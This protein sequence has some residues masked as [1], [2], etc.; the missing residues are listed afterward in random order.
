[1][2]RIVLAATALAVL[3]AGSTFAAAAPTAARPGCTGNPDSVSQLNFPV[4][5]EMAKALVAYP[6]KAPRGIVAFAHGYGHTMHSWKRHVARTAR[7][8]GVIAVVPNYRHQLDIPPAKGKTLPSSRGWRVAEG[9]EDIIAVTQLL[10]RRC[11]PKGLNVLYGISMGGNTSGLVLAAKPKAPDGSPLFDHWVNIEGA[12][13]VTETYLMARAIAPGN[14]YAK[15]A[16]EDIEQEMGGPIESRHAVYAERTVVNRVGD[17]GASGVKSV[18]MVH[19]VLDGLV[20][21]DHSRQLQALLVAHRIPVGMRTVVTRS[22]GS[23]PGTTADGYVPT[24]QTSPFAGHASE[25]SETHD[26]GQA[27]FAALDSLYDTAP[28]VCGERVDDGMTGLSPS[29]LDTC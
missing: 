10:E 27:G 22:A 3:A 12:A 20:S 19:G 23:E 13:N 11:A 17:I 26:V 14:A 18:L 25:A 9:A 28:D 15:N 4:G 21:Y 5:K 6:S 29:A 16:A 1:M 7:T 8:L 24:G 2:R